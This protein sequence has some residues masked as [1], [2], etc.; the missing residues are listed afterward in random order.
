MIL[1]SIGIA[2]A[3]PVAYYFMN[4]WLQNYIYR[5]SVGIP[6]LL[7]AAAIII[8][9]TFITIAYKAYQAPVLNPAESIKTE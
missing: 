3:I 2:I 7:T 5:T 9:I 4:N 1:V 6:L 8:A